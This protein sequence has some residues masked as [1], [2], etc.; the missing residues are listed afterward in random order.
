MISNLV[1]KTA[2]SLQEIHTQKN[3]S[4]RAPLHKRKGYRTLSAGNR[5]FD[6]CCIRLE[7]PFEV[8]SLLGLLVRTTSTQRREYD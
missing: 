1:A 6:V 8:R 5:R 7:E 2:Q 4:E 3:N